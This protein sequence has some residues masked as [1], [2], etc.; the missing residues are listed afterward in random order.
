[1]KQNGKKIQQVALSPQIHLRPETLSSQE[2]Q[3]GLKQSWGLGPL[4]SA[5]GRKPGMSPPRI[6]A[7]DLPLCLGPQRQM[8]THR[9]TCTHTREGALRESGR[10]RAVG[11]RAWRSGCQRWVYPE[12]RDPRV[13]TLTPHVI[14][15][16]LLPASS[17]LPWLRRKARVERERRQVGINWSV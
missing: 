17:L 6:D 15:G 16:R 14:A 11:R 10:A 8:Y 7:W 4:Y 1:M 12:G 5:P 9:C 3:W 2:H 13:H